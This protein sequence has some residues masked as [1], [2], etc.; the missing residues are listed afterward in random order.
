M[1]IEASFKKYKAFLET[2]DI[3]KYE[4]LTNSKKYRV[5]AYNKFRSTKGYLVVVSNGKVCSREEAIDPY[6]L[7]STFNSFM[8][9]L[10]EQ[11]QAEMDKPTAI[12]QN[13]INLLNSVKPYIK[14]RLEEKIVT[15]I[16]ELD[17]G[18]KRIKD[19][20]SEALRVYES[21]ITKGILIEDEVEEISKLM[22]EFTSLQYKHLY[23]QI[24][25]KDHLRKVVKELIE[26]VNIVPA[27]V[28]RNM[29]KAIEVFEYL[30]GE[31]YLSGIYKSLAQYEKDIQG[32]QVPFFKQ[33][34]WKQK[35]AEN[36][37]ERNK[38]EFQQDVLPMLRN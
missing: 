33:N 18:Y 10:D 16:N 35:L 25:N 21:V 19:I 20:H 17:Q 14:N 32:K 38:K 11:G 2:I 12:F 1:S 34:N 23:L 36:S 30:T 9:G 22:E 24:N 28:K 6:L 26:A 31:E 37:S 3:V 13:T 5:A 27:E 8:F 15:N 4:I 7:F 29:K